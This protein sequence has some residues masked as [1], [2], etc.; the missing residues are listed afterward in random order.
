MEIPKW[1]EK[2][3]YAIMKKI[4]NDKENINSDKYK[5]LRDKDKNILRKDILFAIKYNETYDYQYM[6]TDFIISDF[7]IS[8]VLEIMMEFEDKTNKLCKL[9]WYDL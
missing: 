3:I 4:Y 9:K 6:N 2:I 5:V 7:I 1:K 8:E